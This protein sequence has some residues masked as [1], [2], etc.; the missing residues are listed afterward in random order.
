MEVKR[1]TTYT[2]E[3]ERTLKCEDGKQTPYI[4]EGMVCAH[5]V[6]RTLVAL[7]TIRTNLIGR[8]KVVPLYVDNRER[9]E[10]GNPLKEIPIKIHK[11]SGPYKSAVHK[12][13]LP[14]RG[15]ILISP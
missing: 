5:I 6:F 4:Q 9:K 3:E 8:I 15:R 14:L 2:S 13:V 1:K 10:Q 11:Q 12:Q 7:R